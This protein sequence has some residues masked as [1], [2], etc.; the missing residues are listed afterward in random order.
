[1]RNESETSILQDGYDLPLFGLDEGFFYELH[2]PTLVCI[3]ASLI[4]SIISIV[5]SFKSHHSCSFFSWTKCDRFIVYLAICDGLFNLSH[6]S[7]HVI[8][9][10]ARDH[11]RPR[12]LCEMF[13]FV[14][15]IFSMAQN[16]VVGIIAIN[17]FMMI[18]LRK[19]LKFGKW[20]WKLLVVAFGVPFV[21]AFVAWTLGHLGPNGVM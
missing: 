19:N 4:C 12:E 10:I 2:I 15:A 16:I 11:V 14:T 7:D 18:C 5:V 3:S 17:I 1:M 8:V 13:G 9:V 20:D 6:G 21:T